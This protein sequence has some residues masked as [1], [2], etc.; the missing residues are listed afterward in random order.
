MKKGF[1]FVLFLALLLPSF[2]YAGDNTKACSDRYMVREGKKWGYIDHAGNVVI[3]A[4]F[5]STAQFSEGLA[6]VLVEGS[7]HWRG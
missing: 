1:V 7:D 5:D 4:R 2:C 3:P 6:A